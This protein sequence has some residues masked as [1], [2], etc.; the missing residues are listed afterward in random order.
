MDVAAV[1]HAVG[2]D[3]A[4]RNADR[5]VAAQFQGKDHVLLVGDVL[6]RA[7]DQLGVGHVGRLAGEHFRVGAE[8]VDAARTLRE[9]GRGDV[10]GQGHG[11]LVGRNRM[12]AVDAQVHDALGG[13]SGHG[14][15]ALVV[16]LRDV[17]HAV[18][19]ALEVA[20]VAVCGRPAV[21]ERAGGLQPEARHQRQRGAFGR[22]SEEVERLFGLEVLGRGLQLRADVVHA[23]VVGA[24]LALVVVG[25][26]VGVVDLVAHQD[27][28]T[29]VLENPVVG[30]GAQEAAAG[31]E[32]HLVEG[33]HVG[34]VVDVGQHG[35]DLADHL[36]AFGPY[37]E[38]PV[39][40]ARGRVGDFVGGQLRAG[41]RDVEDAVV[42][43]SATDGLV[44][45]GGSRLAAP[46]VHAA[47]FGQLVHRA[48]EVALDIVL[49]LEDFLF[50][51]GVLEVV[52]HVQEVARSG[53][54]AGQGEGYDECLF[55]VRW[56]LE[57]FRIRSSGKSA[58]RSGAGWGRRVP[59]PWPARDRRCPLRPI[60]RGSRT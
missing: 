3:D 55:H 7:P 23:L 30:V 50:G 16:G 58:A 27:H 2:I 47:L 19:L 60:R 49:A 59:C 4:L 53:E 24:A 43:G 48:V 12:Q 17:V 1:G 52:V 32:L 45:T 5:A 54:A 46:V 34:H 51:E 39:P 22:G 56:L 38:I 20:E 10:R 35:V 42:E 6:R 44:R 41:E 13:G 11:V 9:G 8:G 29:L 31:A 28:G 21:E 18:G 37:V 15:L 57:R 33:V 40:A 14:P 36:V 26:G 25:R